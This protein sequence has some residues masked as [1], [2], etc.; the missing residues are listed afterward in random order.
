MTEMHVAAEL[1][2]ERFIRRLLKFPEG[3]SACSQQS[4][5]RLPV[6]VA[7]TSGHES[8]AR[9]LLPVSGLPEEVDMQTILREASALD[10]GTG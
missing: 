9:M 6:H 4:Q 3:I 10:G 1:G 8:I 2:M 7:A 5:G